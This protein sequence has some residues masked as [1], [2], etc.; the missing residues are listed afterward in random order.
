MNDVSQNAG[1]RLQP[2]DAAARDYDVDF[3]RLPGVARLRRRVQSVLFGLFPEGSRLLELNCG[4]GTDAIALAMAGRR[5]HAT[6]ASPSMIGVARTKARPL[7]LDQL[8]VFDILP[9]DR[10]GSLTGTT[11]DGVFSNMGGLNC[12]RDLSPIFHSL[13]AITVPG[14]YCVIVLLSGFSLWESLSFL[15]RGTPRSAL[16]RSSASGVDVPVGNGAVRTYFHSPAALRKSIS[17]WFRSVRAMALNVFTP[18]PGSTQAHRQL[19]RVLPVLEWLEDRSA[20]LPL[21]RHG[22][23]HTLF[24]LQRT[25][26]P[27]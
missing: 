18:P 6:D 26:A 27:Q 21:I 13:A 17:P 14:S 10:T 16:R 4:T 2:F 15:L 25:M 11:F 22:G 7:N 5:V 9:F 1:V 12:V 23:D 19:A 24:V 8:L 3:G 20:S